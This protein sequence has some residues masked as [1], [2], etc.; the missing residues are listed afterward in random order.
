V[1]ARDPS[2]DVR[3]NAVM[4]H[5]SEL[6]EAR[7]LDSAEALIPLVRDGAN[8]H[9]A[10]TV[11]C[12]EAVVALHRGDFDSALPKVKELL[13]VELYETHL[14]VPLATGLANVYHAIQELLVVP[15]G[16]VAELAKIGERILLRGNALHEQLVATDAPPTSS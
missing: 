16:P 11:R 14:A 2:D 6:I 12:L 13:A 1:I 15:T 10:V 5:I 9:D 7:D 3:Q 8:A 4:D